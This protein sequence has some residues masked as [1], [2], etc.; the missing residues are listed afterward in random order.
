[1]NKQ[2]I[3][4]I[5]ACAALIGGGLYWVS[6][7]DSPPPETA[8]APS[9][10][11][12]LTYVGNTLS[13]EQDGRK[14]WELTAQ[15]IEIDMETNHTIMKQIEGTFYQDNGDAVTIRAPKAEYNVE[16]KDLTLSEKVT[17]ESTDGAVLIAD[18][19]LWLGEKRLFNG[20]GNVRLTRGD[21]VIV[22]DKLESDS[23][24]R[25]FKMIGNA[26]ITEG[27]TGK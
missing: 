9:G 22:G 25:K 1:M 4:I 15:I 7:K 27:G 24:F 21:T 17:A 10:G 8:E 18:R 6:G 23:N 26:H 11:A 13:E 3:F 20:E 16:S 5:L 14:V 12:P 19:L 2:R